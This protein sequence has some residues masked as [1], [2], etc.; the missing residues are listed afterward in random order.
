MSRRGFLARTGAGIL[1]LS[2]GLA[3]GCKVMFAPD[4]RAVAAELTGLLRRRDMAH[5]LGRRYI[6]T[7][8]LLEAQSMESLTRTL[9]DSLGIDLDKVTLLPLAN[10]MSALV[11]RIRDDFARG[12]T[13]AVDGWVLSEAEVRVCAIL[14]LGDSTGGAA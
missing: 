11:A 5:E 1:V 9:L 14:Y 4:A 6:S 2:G 10:L 12:R 8:G 3:A 13:A 7:G